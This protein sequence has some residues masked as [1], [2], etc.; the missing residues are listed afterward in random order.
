MTVALQEADLAWALADAVKSDL[1]AIERNHVFM[2]I[3]AGETFA[4]IRGL[5]KSVAIKRIELRPELVQQCTAWL[6]AYAGHKDEQ[7]LRRLITDFVV[8]NIQRRDLVGL[9]ERRVVVKSLPT[10][11]RPISVSA[12]LVSRPKGPRR[13]QR[14]PHYSPPV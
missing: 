14:H 5:V 6:H 1:S 2:A 9:G 8:P 7:Y 11:C 12:F 13:A 3:G 10:W 4:A